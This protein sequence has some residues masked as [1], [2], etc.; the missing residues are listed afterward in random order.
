MVDRYD[1]IPEKFAEDRIL[2]LCRP[3]HTWVNARASWMS[4]ALGCQARNAILPTWE[5]LRAGMAIDAIGGLWAPAPITMYDRGE[6]EMRAT[7]A[8]EFGPG[9]VAG[10]RCDPPGYKVVRAVKW[11]MVDGPPVGH[12]R[13][14]A[15]F[16]G[17]E[18]GTMQHVQQ[19]GSL[20]TRLPHL[21]R[22]VPFEQRE[23][24]RGRCSDPLTPGDV[25]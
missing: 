14:V 15:F 23:R 6:K 25:T 20:D 18:D 17:R 3:F 2:E 19:S 9:G 1:L 24:I 11:M 13:P 8:F 5:M 21:W 7:V 4:Y 16:A 12:S 10:V 22:P